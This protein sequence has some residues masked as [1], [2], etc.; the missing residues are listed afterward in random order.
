[1]P[2]RKEILLVENDRLDVE[3]TLLAFEHHGLAGRVHV[4]SS[5]EEAL[6][7]LG[8][9]RAPDLVL[10]DLNMPQLGGHELLAQL[11]AHQVLRA[12]RVV[13]LSTSGL[14]SERARSRELGAAQ[15]LLKPTSFDA[16][17]ELIGDLARRYL[18]IT[19]AA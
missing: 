15:H 10:L 14:D 19:P 17:V 8:G 16:L 9:G 1:M 4:A 2:H 13:V 7:Y 5:G 12:L 11:R 6:V 3:L 18:L